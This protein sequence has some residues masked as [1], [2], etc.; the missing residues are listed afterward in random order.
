MVLLIPLNKFPDENG[1]ILHSSP[2]SSIPTENIEILSPYYARPTTAQKFSITWDSFPSFV[3][4]TSLQVIN[5]VLWDV[6]LMNQQTRLRVGHKIYF[7]FFALRQTRL[8]INNL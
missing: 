1:D 3:I 2:T 6:L 7:H 4:N 8:L 5:V